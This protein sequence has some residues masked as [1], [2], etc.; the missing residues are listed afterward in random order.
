MKKLTCVMLAAVLL[1]VFT[2]FA[3]CGGKPKLTLY[4]A[5][6]ERNSDEVNVAMVWK[7]DGSK[8]TPIALTDGTQNVEVWGIAESGNSIYVAGYE[9]SEGNSDHFYSAITVW[10]IDGSKVTS[11]ALTDGTQ[12]AMVQGI[13]EIGDSLYAAGWEMNGGINIATVWKI[14]GSTVTPIA[15]TDETQYGVVNDIAEI[16][17]SLYAT[18][19][20]G[21]AATVWKIDGS[22]V[23]PIT[24]INGRRSS[25]VRA[26]GIAEIG[27]GIYVTGS[28]GSGVLQDDAMVWKIDDS[29]V[30]LIA[31]I[32]GKPDAGTVGVA[33][34]GGSLYAGGFNRGAYEGTAMVWK[35]D[36][37]TVTPIVLPEGSQSSG[38]RSIAE[39][40]G[41]IYAIGSKYKVWKIDGSTVTAIALT[42]ETQ[43][44]EVY[45]YDMVESEGSLY[46]AGF[47]K[48]SN[49]VN[50]ATVWKIT[51]GE[52]TPI[53]L[54]EG[55]QNSNVK[56]VLARME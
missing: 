3:G 5:G 45:I 28:E 36:G 54:T 19:D 37:S 13:A 20:E 4:A 34:G 17:G 24:Q 50:V 43:K 44:A 40:G 30:T 1:T 26:Q 10:K 39:I 31:R 47:E 56:A 35:I 48:N 52:T 55:D 29:T 12:K 46:A 15:L 51:D 11:I 49:E 8:V 41:S 38:V 32:N 23:T 6:Y 2:A 33:A 18:G 21:L 16:G 27:G 22:T 42:D 53:P 25:H 14:D 7:I 9:G